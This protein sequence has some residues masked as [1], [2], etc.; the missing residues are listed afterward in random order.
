[1]PS[2]L[3][4]IAQ[5]CTHLETLE[6]ETS[7]MNLNGTK[8]LRALFSPLKN[9][10]RIQVSSASIPEIEKAVPELKGKLMG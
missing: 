9:L 7:N 5:A 2:I 3:D 10:R 6:I 8:D 1:V 4:D